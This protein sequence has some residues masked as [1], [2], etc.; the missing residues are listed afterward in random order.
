METLS[1]WPVTIELPVQWG[2]MD[3]LGHV[4]NV[5]YLRW[6]ESA[7][8]EYFYRSG[9]WGRREQ[10]IGPILARSTIDYRVQL[11]YPDSIRASCTVSK[12]G[13]TSFT[14]TTRLRSRK[15][16][17]AIVAEGES[18]CVM[19]SY[20]TGAKIP[21]SDELRQQIYALESSA[22]EPGQLKPDG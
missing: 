18:I 13:N 1:R 6:F 7:R 5:V 12:L 15:H 14:M 8:I 22:P 17:R 21:L 11:T 4:N 10:G 20:E 16:D 2:D 9:L 3:A 19:I